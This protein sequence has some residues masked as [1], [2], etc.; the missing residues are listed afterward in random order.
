MQPRTKSEKASL[1]PLTLLKRSETVYP[2]SPE[3]AVL[4]AFP[5]THPKRA[6]WITFHCPEFTALCPI[7]NQPDF[8]TITIEYIPGRLCLES[9]SLKLYLFSYRNYGAFHEEVVNRILDDLI[10][11]IKPKQAK[12]TGKFNPR[13]GIAISVAAEHKAAKKA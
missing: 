8:G 1:S 11:A 10:K 6:Y 4:E 3:Q 5:N 12:I 7:T 2:D 9:K 13:G